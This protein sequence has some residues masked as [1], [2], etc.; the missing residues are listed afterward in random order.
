ML[1]VHALNDEEKIQALCRRAKTRGINLSLQAGKYLLTKCS[2]DTVA[3]FSIL[4]QLDQA[5]LAS[6]HKL[7]I[8][9]IKKVL[10]Q[11]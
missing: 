5:S 9:F 2:R 11:K 10:F 4:E 7:T 3:L 1:Q 8:P 6:Q